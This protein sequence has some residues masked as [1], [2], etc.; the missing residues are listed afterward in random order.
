MASRA[1]L[2][3]RNPLIAAT[4]NFLADNAIN[5]DRVDLDTVSV[6]AMGDKT[7]QIRAEVMLTMPLQ[8]FIQGVGEA[9]DRLEEE[10]AAEAQEAEAQAIADQGQAALEETAD[11]EPETLDDDGF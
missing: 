1:Q 2:L 4:R 9:Q 10:A 6:V 3:K 8:K 5:P 11:A 7:V